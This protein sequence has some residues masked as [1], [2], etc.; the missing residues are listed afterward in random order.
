M[1]I[2]RVIAK[3]G[4]QYYGNPAGHGEVEIVTGDL[5]TGLVPTGRHVEV[6]SY[7]APV[8]PEN[9]YCIGLNYRAHAEETG[10]R[11]QILGLVSDGQVHS[12]LEHLVAI[13]EA[14]DRSA[15]KGGSVEGVDD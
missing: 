1:K 9:I 5:Y 13:L 12:D 4:K 7:L 11:L 3:D 8:A 6:A 10:G 2:V 14:A 15:A